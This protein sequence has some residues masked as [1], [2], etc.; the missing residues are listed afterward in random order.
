MKSVTGK[1]L[2]GVLERN[3]WELVRVHGKHLIHG[4][5]GTNVRLSIPIHGNKTLKTGLL[6]HLLKTAGLTESDL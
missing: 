4:K 6:H 5:Q 1:D 2:S 3:Q